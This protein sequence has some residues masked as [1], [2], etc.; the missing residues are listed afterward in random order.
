[1]ASVLSE[2][3]IGWVRTETKQTH[4]SREK[5]LSNG[6]KSTERNRP[7][8]RGIRTGA[9]LAGGTTITNP[10]TFSAK[11]VRFFLPRCSMPRVFFFFFFFES[12]SCLR[13]SRSSYQLFEGLSLCADSVSGPLCPLPP[14]FSWSSA[15]MDYVIISLNSLIFQANPESTEAQRGTVEGVSQHP[16]LV[17][18]PSLAW[19]RAHCPTIQSW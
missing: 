15:S 19:A 10:P 3:T 2:I 6:G 1:M 4:R 18:R 9:L 14:N 5:I 11:E 8:A 7:K 12:W 16:V 17:P 13:L